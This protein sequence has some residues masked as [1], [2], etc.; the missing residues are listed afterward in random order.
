MQKGQNMAKESELK[1][2]IKEGTSIG[3]MTEQET[4]EETQSSR[5]EN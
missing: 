3:R 5:R 4:D 2:K 1:R